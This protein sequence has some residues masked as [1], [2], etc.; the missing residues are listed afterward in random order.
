MIGTPEAADGEAHLDGR[1]DEI[2][3]ALPT[4]YAHNYW[5]LI[6]TIRDGVVVLTLDYAPA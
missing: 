5:S 2:E 3:G 1:S 6:P 4:P